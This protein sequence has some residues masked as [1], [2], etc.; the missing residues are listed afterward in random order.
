MEPGGGKQPPVTHP[1]GIPTVHIASR[2]QRGERQEHP[3]GSRAALRPPPGRCGCGWRGAGRDS[4]SRY[5]R[6]SPAY[7]AYTP[8]TVEFYWVWGRIS[9]F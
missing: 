8:P 4:S 5:T 2:R 7:S 3:E 6:P 9:A 1:T